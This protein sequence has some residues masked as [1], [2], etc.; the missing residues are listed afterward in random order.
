M[1]QAVHCCSWH[2]ATPWRFCIVSLYRSTHTHVFVCVCVCDR[3]LPF[4]V[5]FEESLSQKGSSEAGEEREPELELYL[6][7]K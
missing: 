2:S 7:V 3:K 1:Y 4:K 6:C 5:H